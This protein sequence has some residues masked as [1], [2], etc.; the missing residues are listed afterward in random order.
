MSKCYKRIIYLQADLKLEVEVTSLYVGS[1]GLVYL[2]KDYAGQRDR[3]NSYA[4]LFTL[5]HYPSRNTQEN[6]TLFDNSSLF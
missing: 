5:L 3:A 1:N 6:L 4:K 2:L